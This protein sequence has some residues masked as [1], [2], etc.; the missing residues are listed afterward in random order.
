[1]GRI[2]KLITNEAVPSTRSEWTKRGNDYWNLRTVTIK[3][4]EPTNSV[5]SL[6]Q[7]DKGTANAK[8][9]KKQDLIHHLPPNHL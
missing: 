6:K 1:M 4:E 3:Q 9:S 8:Q 2:R 7:R 5:C